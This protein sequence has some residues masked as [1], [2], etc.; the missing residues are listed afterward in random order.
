MNFDPINEGLSGDYP[1]CKAQHSFC[2]E[3]FHPFY[4]SSNI[5]LMEHFKKFICIPFNSLGVV[6]K[7]CH[8]LGEMG[9]RASVTREDFAWEK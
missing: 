4:Y 7:L 8:A 3:Y 1:D 9:G 6:W 5:L 2:F